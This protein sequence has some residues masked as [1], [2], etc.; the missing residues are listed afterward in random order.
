M[1]SLDGN[2]NSIRPS[3]QPSVVKIERTCK[4][5]PK[6]GKKNFIDYPND[7]DGV[8]IGVLVGSTLSAVVGYFLILLASKK[9][10]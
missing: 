10:K 9:N 8:K 6:P 2:E 5:L 3:Q 7:M 4:N 1:A